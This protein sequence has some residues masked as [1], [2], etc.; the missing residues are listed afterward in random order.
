VTDRPAS[1]TTDPGAP[2]PTPA[3][4]RV[5]LFGATGYTGRLAAQSMVRDGVRP[6]LAGRD[7]ERLTALAAAL[8][9]V[10]GPLEHRTADVHDA[11]SVAALVGAGDVLVTTVGPFARWGAP[12]VEAAVATGAHYVD[13]TGEGAFVRRVFEEYGPRAE[14]AGTVLLT[15]FGYDYV[16]GNL[17]AGIALERAGA[18]GS[19]GVDVG[20]F[21][22]G[23]AR[24]AMSGGTRASALGVVT[25]PSYGFD[26]G[27]L[28]DRRA[29]AEMFTL[30]AGGRSRPVVSIGAT[31]QFTLPRL[32]P[33]LRRVRV[34]LGWFGPVT[35][36]LRGAAG[37]IA[38]MDAVPGVRTAAG[39]L[40]RAVAGRLPGGSTGGPDAAT[41]AR[42]GSLVVA[43]TDPAAD[44]AAPVRVELVGPNGYT[45]TGDLLAWAARSLSSGAAISRAGA[46][47]PVDAFGLP[48]LR[49]ACAA[50]GLRERSA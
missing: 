36:V 44:G 26:G 21:L 39:R 10:G 22:T 50:M 9:G 5:V 8:G 27:E 16:P 38:V 49:D 11:A 48:V 34:G 14:A 7:P 15:A 32:D 6:V 3:T 25:G 4:G 2:A 29:G 20:Y 40:G 45:L 33:G 42:T 35:P 37:A 19:Q 17:A 24:G 12:A 18:G 31:E 13:S 23:P 43:L 30:P 41:R 47:G 28:V 1:G 46:L